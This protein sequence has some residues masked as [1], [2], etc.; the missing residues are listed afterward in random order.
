MVDP[1]PTGRVAVTSFIYLPR[2]SII[3]S[4]KLDKHSFQLTRIVFLNAKIFSIRNYTLLVK[5]IKI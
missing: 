1:P 4:E 5:D 3:N 2:G